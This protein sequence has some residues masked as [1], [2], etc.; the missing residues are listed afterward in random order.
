MMINIMDKLYERVEK[1]G[2]VCVGLDT[3]LEYIPEHLPFLMTN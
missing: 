3:S 1:R 2:V